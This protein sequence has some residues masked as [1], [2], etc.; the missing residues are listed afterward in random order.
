M[1]RHR[2]LLNAAPRSRPDPQWV[3]QL[4]HASN[5]V[6]A[7]VLNWA[8]TQATVLQGKQDVVAQAL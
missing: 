6:Q 4:A 8:H 3:I 7:A 2:R 5:E 1:S